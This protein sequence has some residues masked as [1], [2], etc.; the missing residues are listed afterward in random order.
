VNIK[1]YPVLSKGNTIIL[2][3]KK[4]SYHSNQITGKGS[5]LQRILKE[6]KLQ[7]KKYSEFCRI[8]RLMHPKNHFAL[9][10][11]AVPDNFPLPFFLHGKKKIPPKHRL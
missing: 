5:P 3:I 4:L 10:S 8:Y 11:L 2:R 7:I 9:V 6:V 1:K